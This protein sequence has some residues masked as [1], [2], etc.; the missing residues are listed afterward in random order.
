[1][2]KRMRIAIG[3]GL[4]LVLTMSGCQVVERFTT[5]EDACISEI[6][7]F[8]DTFDDPAL[9]GWAQFDSGG[10]SAAIENGVMRI[11]VSNNGQLAWSNPG[12]QFDD[13]VIEVAAIP[14]SGPDNNAYGVIC[15][16]TDL[17]NFYVF[18]VSADGYYAIGKYDSQW[19]EI[20][21]LTG[22]APNYYQ[23]STAIRQGQANNNLLVRC[24]GNELTLFANGELLASVQDNS[25]TTGDVGV[26]GGSFELGT[27]AVEFDDFRAA[28]P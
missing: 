2:G 22:E 18:L 12:R 9:C 16:Y 26:T 13:V 14:V 5:P 25:H 23:P 10:A 20:Q 21:Y 7:G 8:V 19:A 27:V 1:M 4:L 17:Q 11:D 6:G 24:V 28:A 3:V 15:R